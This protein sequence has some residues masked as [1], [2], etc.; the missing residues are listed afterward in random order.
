MH[1]DVAEGMVEALRLTVYNWEYNKS[2]YRLTDGLKV[3]R[4]YSML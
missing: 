2:T 3:I 1:H 4:S